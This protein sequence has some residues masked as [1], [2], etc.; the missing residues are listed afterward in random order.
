ME[1]DLFALRSPDPLPH[2]P[3]RHGHQVRLL[4]P[5]V[6]FA[7][8][9]PTLAAINIIKEWIVVRPSYFVESDPEWIASP[10]FYSRGWLGDLDSALRLASRSDDDQTDRPVASY[11]SCPLL[12]TRLDTTLCWRRTATTLGSVGGAR[13][14]RRRGDLSSD[15]TCV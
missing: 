9:A 4:R 2:I 13:L 12:R 6:H 5:R 3:S 10:A 11:G 7:H 8:N 15:V 14:H 1:T